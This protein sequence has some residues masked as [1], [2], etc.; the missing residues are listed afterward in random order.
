M[1][2]RAVVGLQ[3]GDEGKGKI[4]DFL[5]P[6]ADVVARCQGGPNAGHSVWYEGQ[7]HVLHTL[8]CGLFHPQTECYHGHSMVINPY[9]LADE[10][11]L[12]TKL[13]IT[14]KGRAFFSP[15]A[16][17]I[18][19]CHLAIDEAR[20]KKRGALGT[21]KK[22]IGPTYESR[23]ARRGILL[24][25]LRDSSLLLEKIEALHTALEPELTAIHY[26]GPSPEKVVRDLRAFCDTLIPLLRDA[27]TERLHEALGDG[28]RILLEGAQGHFLDLDLGTIPF[29]TSSRTTAAGLLDG[30]G[31]PPSALTGVFGVAKAYTTRVGNGPFPA[32]LNDATGERLRKVGAEYGATTGRPRRCGWLDA[33]MLRTACDVNGVTAIALTKLDVLTGFETIEVVTA[34]DV[35]GTIVERVPDSPVAIERAR[36]GSVETFPGW[37]EDIT[38]VQEFSS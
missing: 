10:L 2:V 6:G 4:I 12:L 29:V 20:E 11:V 15:R 21:T 13:G 5:S 34:W 37:T 14:W 16:Q 35:D 19:P 27:F 30:L 1:S 31:L 38:G 28:K 26:D 24:D 36:I 23:A 22:G 9:T 17:L 32:E 33:V 3:W 7:L 18:L 25:Y 8:S